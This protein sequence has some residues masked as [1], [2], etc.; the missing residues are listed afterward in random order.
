MSEET[1][2]GWLIT[3]ESPGGGPPQVYNV[4]I[5]EERL[6]VEA[7]KRVLPNHE[8]AIVKIKSKLT[9]QLFEAL[10]MKTG[11]V[12]LGARKKRPRDANQ[13]TKSIADISP[14]DKIDA[15][16]NSMGGKDSC[17]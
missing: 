3:V 2:F 15:S 8:A 7:V 17:R 5:L 12:M 16:G 9:K 6:A 4:A 11:D 13:L 14:A 1:Y 10:K